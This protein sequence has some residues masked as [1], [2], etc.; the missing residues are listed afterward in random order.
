MLYSYF[1]KTI[2]I[3]NARNGNNII[4]QNLH[5]IGNYKTSRIIVFT[6][7][8]LFI[9]IK[10]LTPAYIYSRFNP[11]LIDLTEKWQFLLKLVLTYSYPLILSITNTVI[12]PLGVKIFTYFEFNWVKSEHELSL[13]YKNFAT[14][15]LNTLITPLLANFS[16]H[17]FSFAQLQQEFI[18]YKLF[19][20]Q[21]IIQLSFVSNF[22]ELL[23]LPET[24]K[25]LFSSSSKKS[26]ILK[27][28]FKEKFSFDYG[29]NYAFSLVIFLVVI[30]FSILVPILPILG[31]FYFL[32]RYSIDKYNLCF[33]F[34]KEYDSSGKLS[35]NSLHIIICC[36]LLMEFSCVVM[37]NDSTAIIICICF[38]LVIDYYI[39][40]RTV[41]RKL[42]IKE[43]ISLS[44]FSEKDNDMKIKQENSG[45]ED[46]HLYS[47]SDICRCNIKS[48]S[49]KNLGGFNKHN[50]FDLINDYYSNSNDQIK[51][52]EEVF[53]E[54]SNRKDQETSKNNMF[55]S[56]KTFM[57]Q[58]TINVSGSNYANSGTTSKEEDK[59]EN[60]V[61]MIINKNDNDNQIDDNNKYKKEIITPT[62]TKRKQ[63][64][65][66]FNFLEQQEGFRNSEFFEMDLSWNFYIPSFLIPYSLSKKTKYSSIIKR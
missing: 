49:E 2:V 66:K 59:K 11:I 58:N 6:I 28:S 54:A 24:Y 16:V 40:T 17:D 48:V 62:N 22:V 41:L 52:D 23:S 47:K 25:M 18:D 32:V 46:S 44:K 8:L 4:W 9:S 53:N 42:S 57:K 50:C 20:I 56:N 12:I 29:Y 34:S 33:I 31:W 65:D 10:I 5:S 13:L 3:E 19:I 61:D 45:I 60:V 14:I 1:Y 21:Y 63:S 7:L 26:S 15:L 30:S 55:I 35:K 36:I 51:S 64:Y 38:F 43:R 39:L 37:I 27:K